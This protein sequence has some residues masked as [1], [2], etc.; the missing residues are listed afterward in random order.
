MKFVRRSE[1]DHAMV[2]VR[3]R[4]AEGSPKGEMFL[5]MRQR[6]EAFTT[7]SSGGDMSAAEALGLA[8]THAMDLRT[9]IAVVDEDGVWRKEWGTLHAE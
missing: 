6:G 9:D 4:S 2:S 8:T 1:P 7:S 3:L 5:P